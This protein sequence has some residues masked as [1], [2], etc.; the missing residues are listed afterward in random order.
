[1]IT[2]EEYLKALDTVLEYHEQLNKVVEFKGGNNVYE[3][4]RFLDVHADRNKKIRIKFGIIN[5]L[6]KVQ[7]TSDIDYKRISIDK[8]EGMFHSNIRGFGEVSKKELS[9][10]LELF[11]AQ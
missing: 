7:L 4:F 6:K 3:F 2:K 5:Y 8:I 1:M 11:K 10:V 9:R